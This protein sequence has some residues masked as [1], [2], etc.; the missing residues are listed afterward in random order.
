MSLRIL[1][2]NVKWAAQLPHVREVSLRGIA[3]L[4][5]WTERLRS[6]QLRP[7]EREGM[8]QVLLVAADAKYL[9]IRF[10]EL[11]ISVLVTSPADGPPNAVFLTGAFNSI[12]FFAFCERML[13][14]TPYHYG[15]VRVSTSPAAM[16]LA[17][18]DAVTFRAELRAEPGREPSRCGEDGWEG[19]IFLPG[20]R[21]RKPGQRKWFFARLQGNTHAYPFVEGKDTMT[22]RPT[23]AN[24]TLQALK[25]CRFVAK[26]WLIR[27]D[28]S[29]AKS[30]TYQSCEVLQV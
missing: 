25:D 1:N 9:C 3:D 4:A 18:K 29:H 14:A 2:T 5:Y 6:E 23:S 24:E 12:R 19:L 30:K 22:I 10:R 26:E 21:R 16:E 7:A 28:A 15:D 27:E 20:A 11:S 17:E 13:F 8:A